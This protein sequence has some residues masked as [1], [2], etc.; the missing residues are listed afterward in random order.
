M[1][2]STVAAIV[3]LVVVGIPVSW[4]IFNLVIGALVNL[5]R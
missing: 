2:P 4:F 1:R 5:G 3:V